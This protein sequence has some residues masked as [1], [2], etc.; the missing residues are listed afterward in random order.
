MQ[1]QVFSFHLTAEICAGPARWCQPGP[2]VAQT[3]SLGSGCLG[4][5]HPW[6]AGD[7]TALPGTT[8]G[9]AICLILGTALRADV[10][11]S[12]KSCV[13]LGLFVVKATVELCVLENPG[14]TQCF[15]G[16]FTSWFAQPG[17]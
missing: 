3:G 12:R 10:M 17:L 14:C 1:R 16:E 13:T 6:V 9:R 7:G 15:S 11:E 4:I 2:R 8:T 5:P